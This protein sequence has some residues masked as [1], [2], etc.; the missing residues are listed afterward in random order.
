L[1]EFRV[2]IAKLR[3]LE[4]QLRKAPEAQDMSHETA[5]GSLT[6][7]RKDAAACLKRNSSGALGQS[8][9]WR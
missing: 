4:N 8:Y 1:G 2:E 3:L 9:V 7:S 6:P 5:S